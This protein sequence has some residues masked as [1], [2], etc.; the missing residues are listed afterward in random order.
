MNTRMDGLP[1]RILARVTLDENDC[2]IWSGYIGDHGYGLAWFDGKTRLVHRL[3]YRLLVGEP[4]GET[5]DHL[6]R[7]RACCRPEHLDPCSRGENTLR[8][9]SIPARNLAKE[10]CPQGH[11]YSHADRRGWRK[12]R[13]CDNRQQRERRAARLAGAEE[14]A[15]A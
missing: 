4:E 6:C 12:C 7:V 10:R 14:R 8:G 2:W 11:E 15:A 13:T 5:L 3:V 1:P 9:D